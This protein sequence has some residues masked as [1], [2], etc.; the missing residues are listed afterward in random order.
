MIVTTTPFIRTD[1]LTPK[2]FH[3]TKCI[4]R[5]DIYQAT[6]READVPQFWFHEDTES[7][8]CYGEGK[9]TPV[10]GPMNLE[11]YWMG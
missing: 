8:Y 2:F 10:Y 11:L 6:Y 7:E 3:R 9:A 4:C 5:A 1:S